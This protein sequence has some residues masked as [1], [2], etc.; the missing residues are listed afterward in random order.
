MDG[1][2]KIIIGRERRRQWS[3]ADKLCIVGETHELGARVCDV[4]ARPGL[5]ESLLFAWRRQVRE[6]LL[7]EPA[8]PMFMP[9]QMLETPQVTPAVPSQALVHG[10]RGGLTLMRQV[11]TR[12]AIQAQRRAPP[13]H[14]PGALP[15][16]GLASLR[17]GAAPTG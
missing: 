10:C 2:V 15:R 3:R 17:G 12:H 5:C 4:A 14:S 11:C 7:V 16:H 9:V 6:G 8:M 13:S 1:V